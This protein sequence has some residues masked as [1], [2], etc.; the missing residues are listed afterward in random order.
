MFA[1]IGFRLAKLDILPPK[2]LVCAVT[3]KQGVR[4]TIRLVK[5][6]CVC[7]V[8]ST[9]SHSLMCQNELGGGG[10]LQ[11]RFKKKGKSALRML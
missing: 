8:G 7:D 5:N 1:L 9:T 4:K 2:T 3:P 11:V 10:G 6:E